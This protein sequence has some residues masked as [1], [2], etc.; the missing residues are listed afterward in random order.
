[1]DEQLTKAIERILLGGAVALTILL[2]VV[3]WLI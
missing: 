2:A 3:W 1:M